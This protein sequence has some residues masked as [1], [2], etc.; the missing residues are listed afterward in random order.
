MA[1]ARERGAKRALALPVSAPFH[2]PLM[3]PA[4]E[5]LEPLLA[6]VEFRDPAV[7]VVANVDAAPVASGA[8]ARD[9]LVRQVD[10]AVRW[11]E[12]VRWMAGEGGAEMFL[13]IGPGAVLT[14]LVKRIVPGVAAASLSEPEGLEAA[15]A[16]AG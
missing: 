15:L 12:S 16:A 6:A 8:A 4:R 3:R 1:L 11:V 10:G 7:P 14:G 9:A 13:E 2:S 5:G